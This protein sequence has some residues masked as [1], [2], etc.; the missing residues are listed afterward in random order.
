MQTRTRPLLIAALLLGLGTTASAFDLTVE[1]LNARSDQ[2]TVDGALFGAA[3]SWLRE[4]LTGA[5]EPAGAKVVLV[6]RNLP[7]GPYAL[8]VFHDENGNGKLDANVAGIPLERYGFSRDAR[9]R[10]GPP[11]FADAALDLQADTTI[12]VNLR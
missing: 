9:G 8:S 6:Y 4:S 2:G 3:A 12:T 11:P 7:A 5:R 1:V 10:M